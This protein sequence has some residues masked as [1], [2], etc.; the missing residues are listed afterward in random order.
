ML[1]A[2]VIGILGVTL[3]AAPARASIVF[4][5]SNNITGQLGQVCLYNWINYNQGGGWHVFS[6]DYLNNYSCTNLINHTWNTGGDMNDGAS[7]LVINGSPMSTN[8]TRVYFYNWVNC[9]IV[10][11]YAMYWITQGDALRLEPN[12]GSVQDTSQTT[13]ANWYDRWTSVKVETVLP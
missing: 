1:A 4:G 9:N 13:Q 12:L 10:G 6:F 8:G 5:C 7:S 3:T 11:G 2:I